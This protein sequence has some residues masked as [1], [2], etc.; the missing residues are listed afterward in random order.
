M[1]GGQH[2]TKALQ[3]RREDYVNQRKDVPRSLDTVSAT[4]LR[5][6]TPLPLRQQAAGDAQFRDVS[7]RPLRLS[8]WATLLLTPDVRALEDPD[9]RIAVSMRKAGMGTTGRLVCFPRTPAGMRTCALSG[10]RFPLFPH[11]LPPLPSS[12]WPV[13]RGSV[14]EGSV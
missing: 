6:D 3:M 8:S 1:L 7:V 14:C 2:M 12:S 11:H 4:V 10:Q 13:S 5:H 9:E